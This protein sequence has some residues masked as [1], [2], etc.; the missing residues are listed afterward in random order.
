M[1]NKILTSSAIGDALG[2]QMEG[3]SKAHIAASFKNIQT[4]PD[5]LAALKGKVHRW[6]KPGL[7]SSITQIQLLTLFSFKRNRFN[8]KSFISTLKNLPEV[9]NHEYS[10]LRHPGRIEKN[11]LSRIKTHEAIT[12]VSSSPSS[13]I[14]PSCA[15]FSFTEKGYEIQAD[16]VLSFVREFTHDISTLC[17][18]LFLVK[19]ISGRIHT[20]PHNDNILTAAISAS[21]ETEKY[22]KD[23][24][25][26]FFDLGMNPDYVSA[27]QS[28]FTEI[29]ENCMTAVSE[30]KA[31]EIICSFLNRRLKTPVKRATVDHPL[32][33]IPFSVFLC[34]RS[35]NHEENILFHA[36]RNG[37]SSAA[38]A[39]L[40]GIL[41][42]CFIK[43]FDI[44]QKLLDDLVN[45][46]RIL[47]LTESLS[48]MNGSDKLM[49]D[50]I[51]TEAMLTTKEIE[52][53]SA[54][55]KHI[56]TT[57]VKKRRNRT[58]K[59][60]DLTKIT[61]ES[62]TKLDKAKWRKEQKRIIPEE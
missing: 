44:P 41:A 37:G 53:L 30:D 43:D 50:F 12:A 22:I 2:T 17:G 48:E 8:Y 59:E 16:N 61:V 34:S 24:S 5:N 19:L 42:S 62:W 54:R 36:A 21:K 51:E 15:L 33:I 7:Y 11:F 45:R 3:M 56:K 46:K 1:I 18:A 29:F 40:T 6:S 55:T 27:E 9:Q 25:P 57:D 58:D 13:S 49:R 20:S 52:E 14:M 47:A 26:V 28:A 39:S 35:F 32:A 10:I 4:Y 60:N 31:E 38:L 23:K